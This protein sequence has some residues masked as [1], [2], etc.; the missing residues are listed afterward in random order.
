MNA[1][2]R[3]VNNIEFPH[4]LNLEVEK[5]KDPQEAA[6]KVTWAALD[7]GIDIYHAAVAGLAVSTGCKWISISRMLVSNRR[8]ELK[9]MWEDEK[10]TDC[11]EYDLTDTPCDVVVQ[12]EGSVMFE[13]VA[14]KFPQDAYLQDLGVEDYIGLSFKDHDGNLAGHICVMDNEPFEKLEQ[15]EKTLGVVSAA[16][17]LEM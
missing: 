11:F 4:S 8:V 17:A 3:Q 16:V 13:K 15:I 1:Q 6:L 12:S 9:A 10:F 7:K 5:Y 2:H 14:E